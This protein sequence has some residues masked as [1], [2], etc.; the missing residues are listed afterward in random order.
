M[1]S[2]LPEGCKEERRLP[3]SCFLRTMLPERLRQS[4][5]VLWCAALTLL[6]VIRLATAGPALSNDGYQY[7]SEAGNIRL[8]N[9]FSTSIVHFDE[10]QSHGRIPAPLTTFPPGYPVVI[11]LLSCLGLS[12]NTAAVL[13]S[14]LSAIGLIPLMALFCQEAGVGR[15]GTRFALAIVVGNSLGLLLATGVNTDMLFTFL[16]SGAILAC[17]IALRPDNS[18]SRTG[19]ALLVCGIFAGAAYWVRYAA[20]LLLLALIAFVVLQTVLARRLNAIVRAW[21]L[22]SAFLLI[23]PLMLRNYLVVGSWRGGN[24][25]PLFT[26]LHETAMTMLISIH[27]V[28]FA[29]PRPVLGIGDLILYGGLVVL[30]WAVVRSKVPLPIGLTHRVPGLII[31]YTGTYLVLLGYIGSTSP[32]GIAARYFYPLIPVWAV[33]AALLIEPVWATASKLSRLAVAAVLTGYIA[34]NARG[35]PV[36]PVNFHQDL[37]A[38]LQTSIQNAGGTVQDWINHNIPRDAVVTASCGQPTGYVLSRPV[39]S[40]VDKRYTRQDW[41]DAHLVSAMDRFQS[42]WLILYPQAAC[43]FEQRDWPNLERLAHGYSAPGL[44]LAVQTS[45]AA[46][47]RR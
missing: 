24:T 7:L 30:A 4:E 36:K 6:I 15:H 21:P 31:A 40:L 47:F 17:W 33:A 41:S 18:P 19:V 13:C 27:H 25:K 38:R 3:V 5:I 39:L 20:I 37:Q 14:A 11:A 16:S 35:L 9:G 23:G 2:V 29:A 12:L 34:M 42:H 1:L 8:G 10:E 45:D 32:V 26:P 28:L 43:A 46:V 44:S 22:L